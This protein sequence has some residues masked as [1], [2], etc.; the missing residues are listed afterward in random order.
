MRKFFSKSLVS[1]AL[2]ATLIATLTFEVDTDKSI[3]KNSNGTLL[4]YKTMNSG[5]GGGLGT[6]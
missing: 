1:L 3:D 5:S 4:E 2:L 6:W